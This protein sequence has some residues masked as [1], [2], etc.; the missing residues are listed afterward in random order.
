MSPTK[1]M[2]VRQLLEEK[3]LSQNRQLPPVSPSRKTGGLFRYASASLFQTLQSA[4][5]LHLCLQMCASGWGNDATL[6]R[7]STRLH[8]PPPVTQ[9][10]PEKQAE[11]CIADWEWPFRTAGVAS[12][13]QFQ[14][15]RQVWTS[16]SSSSLSSLIKYHNNLFKF[17]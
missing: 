7:G 1:V 15:K 5:E 13:P 6:L 9:L 16:S 11:M 12:P 3:R 8:L 10:Q 17:H 14:T 4:Q 2:D